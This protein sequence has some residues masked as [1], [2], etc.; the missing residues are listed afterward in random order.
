MGC[1]RGIPA[2]TLVVLMAAV[3]GSVGAQDSSRDFPQRP[4]RFVIPYVPGGATDIVARLIGPRLTEILN[5]QIVIDNRVGASGNIA[6]ELVAKSAPDGY[7]LL[8]GNVSTNSINPVGFATTLKFDPAKALSGITLMASIP[9]ALVAGAGFPPNTLK[10]VITYTRAR[11]GQLNHGGPIG[12]YAHLDLLALL[13]ATGMRMVHVPS[14][15]GAGTAIT[16]L[17]N[18]EF[19]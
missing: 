2:T 1:K 7:T 9:N 4:I 11:P 12:S 3:S 14:K 18:G 8:V 10:D 5:Q 19:I 6:L 17:V 16:T 15:G 13:N